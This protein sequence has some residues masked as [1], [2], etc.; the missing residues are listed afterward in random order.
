M[1]NT[2]ART[3]GAVHVWGVRLRERLEEASRQPDRGDIS[4]TTVIIWAA[5][6]TG[7]I[8][9]AGTIAIVINKYNGKLT[10]L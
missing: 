6:I 1:K 9:I 3:C 4:I 2:G 8:L 5:G 7:A 10:G